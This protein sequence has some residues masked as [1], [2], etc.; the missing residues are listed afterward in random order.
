MNFLQE[1]RKDI[2]KKNIA[3]Y[4]L[5]LDEL[6]NE[7]TNNIILKNEL[8]I[9]KEKEILNEINKILNTEKYIIL[10][11][12]GINSILL[13]SN[14]NYTIDYLI[15]EKET[16]KIKMAIFIKNENA[17][18]AIE[19]LLKYKIKTRLIEFEDNIQERVNEILDDLLV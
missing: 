11:K 3:S 15:C 12:I 17:L 18:K 9:G 16:Y 5:A 6:E 2:Y 8:L 7:K 13:N 1:L 4:K 19:Y 14:L 10:P